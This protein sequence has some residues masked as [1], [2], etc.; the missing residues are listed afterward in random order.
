[1]KKRVRDFGEKIASTFCFFFLVDFTIA[2]K[3]LGRALTGLEVPFLHGGGEAFIVLP[4]LV[5]PFLANLQLFA[6]CRFV[7]PIFFINDLFFC[8][9]FTFSNLHTN[10]HSYVANL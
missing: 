8:L 7:F 4:F 6:I 9:S 2:G 1:M 5:L 10:K 3:P